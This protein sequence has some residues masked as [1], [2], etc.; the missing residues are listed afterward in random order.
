MEQMVL[1]FRVESPLAG[2]AMAAQ[3]LILWVSLCYNV[4]YSVEISMVFFLQ[5]QG[6]QGLTWNEFGTRLQGSSWD[7]LLHLC[8]WTL[9]RRAQQS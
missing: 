4:L 9:Q 7:Y 2:S 5:T 1:I 3:W 8:F 6:L